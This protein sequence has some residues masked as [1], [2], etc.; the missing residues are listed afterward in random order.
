LKVLG[1]CTLVL[2]V[3]AIAVFFWFQRYIVYTSEGV[4]LD[5]PFLRGILDEIPEDASPYP[6]PPPEPTPEPIWQGALP[7]EEDEVD[8]FR[9]IWLTGPAFEVVTDWEVALWIAGADAVLIEVND[10]TGR[11]W[12]D[13]EVGLAISYDLVGTVSPRPLLS[14]PGEETWR[15][16]LLFTFSNQLMALRNPPVALGEN[17]DPWPWLNPENLEIQAYIRDLAME[18]ADLGFDEIVLADFTYPPN[19]P[20]ELNQQAQDAVILSFLTELSEA[21]GRVGVVLSLMTTERNWIPAEEESV[22]PLRPSLQ[23]LS[24]IVFRFYCAVEPDTVE[25]TT[26]KNQLLSAARDVLG[27]DY[28]HRFVPGGSSEIPE[29]GS[30]MTQF[31]AG[32]LP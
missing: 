13:S 24:D 26:R 3:L 18:L 8:P 6:I 20:V 12:W 11:L 5:V 9:T 30:W 19:A 14:A 31:A 15:A 27:E 32:N 16:A 7:V 4:R 25:S 21:L 28:L 17:D 2:T 23:A 1:I 29:T 10:E 22:I